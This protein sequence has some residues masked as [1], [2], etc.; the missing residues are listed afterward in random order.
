MCHP[1]SQSDS[2][3]W[4]PPIRENKNAIGIRNAMS[5]SEGSSR[6]AKLGLVASISG[7]PPVGD[8]FERVESAEPIMKRPK[9]HV[10][11]AQRNMRALLFGLL[12][13]NY[14]SLAVD[15]FLT[16]A[17]IGR[18][19]NFDRDDLSDRRREQITLIG[20]AP[21]HQQ[22]A[23]TDILRVNR[24]PKPQSRRCDMAAELDID[25]RTLTPVRGLHVGRL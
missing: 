14:G 21:T 1:V 15:A 13:A 3:V 11:D 22:P 10:V 18:Q 19:L 25:T 6:N 23:A 17:V 9:V 5:V 7:H 24:A 20:G 12:D 16:E 8:R 4:T 2:S